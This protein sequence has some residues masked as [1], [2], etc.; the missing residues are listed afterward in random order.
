MIYTF[1]DKAKVTETG[2]FARLT[3]KKNE[4]IK[5]G[6][7]VYNLY[8]GTP[9]FPTPAHIVKAVSEAAQ[10]AENYKYALVDLPEMLDALV[11]YYKKRYGV[12]I[13]ADEAV[14]VHGSQDGIGHL[15]LAM[16]NACDY[17][18]LPDP[19]YPVFEAGVKLSG[20]NIY[21]YELRKEN[22]FLPDMKQIPEEILHKTKYMIVSYPSNPCGA[23]APKEMY[24]ELIEYAKKYNFFIVNDNAYSDIL[25][26]GR[27]GYSFLSIPGAKEVGIE[28][29]SLSKS[30]DTTGARIS[31]A[32]GNK[33]II[34]AIK[35]IR[36]QYDFGMF[37]PVQ[38]GAIAALT[39]E[40][41]SVKA[42][43]E[44]YRK[45][46]D[47]LCGGFRKYGWNV[48]DSD[49]TMFVWAPIPEKYKTS[50]DFWEV[51]VE[52]TGVLCTPGSAF[53]PAGEGYVRFALVLPADELAKVAEIV[54]KSGII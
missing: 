46:R 18:L 35:V 11:A 43:C 31:F 5:A 47:A 54:G 30:F 23:A 20:A 50:E 16:C 24:Y 19:G 28:F 25:F 8:I 2:I 42:Q 13:N 53:G 41:D 51:L 1:S 34:D 33:H 52:K 10:K 44:E 32:V 14:S 22:G 29:F 27:E 12:E 48:P 4:L 6:R 39:G 17:V 3:D 38:Y 40:T 26:D 21:Y 37:L 7:K 15:G 49:G 9:D 36:S 45:R